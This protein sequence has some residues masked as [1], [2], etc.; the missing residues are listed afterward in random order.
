[1]KAPEAIREISSEAVTYSREEAMNDATPTRPAVAAELGASA[2]EFQN[3]H[4]FVRK[5]R[6]VICS[7]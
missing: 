4:E 7:R 3:L 6:D 5:A 1:V 2:E